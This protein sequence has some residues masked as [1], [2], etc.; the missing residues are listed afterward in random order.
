MRSR[1]LVCA[2]AMFAAL[3]ASAQPP[4]A[5]PPGAL[6]PPAAGGTISLTLQQAL[7]QA[8]LCHPDVASA[9][10]ALVGAQAAAKIQRAAQYPQ[11]DLQFEVRNTQSLGRPINVGG[12]VII[13]S[14][15]RSTQRDVAL[16]LNYNIFQT[17]RD[18][19][20]RRARTLAQAQEYGIPDTQRLLGFEVR[21]TYYNVLASRQLT[22]ALLQSLAA[23]ER[24]REL[25]QARVDAGA[26][27]RSDLLPVEV[28]VARARLESVQAETELNVAL[29]ELRA[30]LLLPPDTSVDL[31]DPL[32]PPGAAIAATVT[33]LVALAETAR[34]DVARQ[35]LTLR[36]AELST[37]VARQEA[38]VQFDANASADYGR[39][40]G[41]SG[42]SW[43]LRAGATYPLF[44]AGAA[45]ANVVAA[46]ADQEQ[47]LQRLNSLL[48]DL[49]REVDSAY[50]RLRQ[51][52]EA[53]A[54]ATVQRRDAEN[55]LAAAEARYQEGLAIIIEVTDAQVA[56][57][58]AQ[59]SEIQSRY[60][61]ALALAT[62]TQALGRD[63][64]LPPA[65]EQ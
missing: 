6:Q 27:A 45:R 61:H 34:P 30:L 10:A 37:R 44:N 58:Q 25:V 36:A 42:E 4:P 38:G 13:S 14:G 54:V 59:V 21:R 28:E 41:V 49:Q 46:Q 2:L 19:L 12:G 26:A 62:L 20:I 15:S 47:T 5:V 32:P 3:M 24:H 35:R 8:L 31:V 55:S 1:L 63:P 50:Q 52:A 65:P 39:H 64:V 48:L 18:N 29:A 22:R 51:A 11:L 53:M 40:T 17:T 33:Q 7:D 57:L 9:R 16:V 56:L 23:A 60:D 43:S